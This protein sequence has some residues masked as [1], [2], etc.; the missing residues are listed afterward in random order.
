M[1]KKP[2]AARED[3]PKQLADL[4]PEHR[5]KLDALEQEHDVIM[6]ADSFESIYKM[7][8]YHEKRREQLKEIPK[9]WSTVLQNDN[10]FLTVYG[11]RAEDIEALKYLEDIWVA[12]EKPDPRAF[13]IEMHF[14]ENPFF[15]NKVLK[16]EY[17]LKKPHSGKVING[18]YESMIT[19]NPERD[20]AIGKMKIDWKNDKVN[21]CKKYPPPPPAKE[22]DMELEDMGSFFNFFELPEDELAIGDRLAQ[23]IFINPISYFKGETEDDDD[24]EDIDSSE[25]D[26]SDQDEIDLERP[27]KKV[28]RV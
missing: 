28:K 6:L 10:M 14:K 11:N 17:K 8:A 2:S 24:D 13:T 18:I 25:D 16:K 27:R 4:S 15:S 5:Q 26:D 1:S 12:R 22:D 23:E 3:L 20:T 9:F 21:L 7:V 19:F